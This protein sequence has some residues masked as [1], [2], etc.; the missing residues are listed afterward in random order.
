MGNHGAASKKKDQGTAV[1]SR[2]GERAVLPASGRA[3]G[4]Y[5]PPPATVV[6]QH[7]LDAWEE[8]WDDK[9]SSLLTTADYSMLNRWS[10]MVN[11]YWELLAQANAM[12]LAEAQGGGLASNPLYKVV[13][14]MAGQIAKMESKL[15]IGPKNRAAL[16]LQIIQG[17]Q[18][19]KDYNQSTSGTRNRPKQN[20][21]PQ[22]DPRFEDD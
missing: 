21:A 10:Q 2:N 22:D 7:A 6:D 18:A 12:P 5:F 20:S 14:A 13:L 17:R 15:G 16:G 11:D 19:E 9:V 4:A 1:D 3:M 8:F